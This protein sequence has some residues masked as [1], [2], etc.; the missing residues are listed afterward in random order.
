MI[1]ILLHAVAFLELIHTSA[2]V[3][4]LLTAGIER[5][6]FGADFNLE[7]ALYRAAFKG[8]TA[9]AAHDAFTVGRMNVLFHNDLLFPRTQ[10][11]KIQKSATQTL[12]HVTASP[13]QMSL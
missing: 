10:I 2:A 3:N 6:A 12:G 1:L 7:L 13:M 5:M 8:F 11:I 9:G 4:Q